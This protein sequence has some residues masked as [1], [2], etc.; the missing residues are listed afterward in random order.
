MASAVPE[1]PQRQLESNAA[2]CEVVPFSPALGVPGGRRL[3]RQD[4]VGDSPR[5]RCDLVRRHAAERD[6]AERA[7][8]TLGQE[9][10]R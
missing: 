7:H 6:P 10:L 4:A 5:L 9:V 8:C 3:R 2:A 1:R